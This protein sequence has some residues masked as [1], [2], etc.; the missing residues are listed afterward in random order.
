MSKKKAAPEAPEI[1]EKP[2]LSPGETAYV[3]AWDYSVLRG[4]FTVN[5]LEPPYFAIEGCFPAG[6]GQDDMFLNEE[7]FK[8][9]ASTHAPEPRSATGLVKQFGFRR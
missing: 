4:T 8:R 5:H 9:W 7:D 2:Y 3:V 6:T 1:I